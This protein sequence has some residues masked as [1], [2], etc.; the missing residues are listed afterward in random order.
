MIRL[1][2]GEPVLWD[3]RGRAK[4]GEID[5]DT[6]NDRSFLRGGVSTTYYNQKQINNSTP[7]GSAD[8]PVFIT[9]DRAEFD[10]TAETAVY[11]GNARAWQ[12]NN[13][14]R[15]DRLSIDQAGGKFL[16]DGNVQTLI[17]NA[18]LKQNSRETALPASASAGSM[19][20]DRGQRVI[21]YRT[22]VEIRQG[23]D[24]I[25]AGSAD[26]Y[27]DEN[28]E[29]TRTV[30]ESNVTISQPSRKASGDWVEYTAETETAVLRGNPATVT[31][32]ENG[33]SQSG[34]L[35]FSMREKRVT[36]EGRTKQNP[37]GRI[38]SVYKI[39]EL[40]P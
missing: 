13:Y 34:Q 6:R 37:S 17:Y 1:R 10:H 14:I 21:K 16:A 5:F 25:T 39:K 2:G 32:P 3:G 8:K 7:F 40:K 29:V 35:S 22:S 28:N 15:G 30:A 19:T 12:E 33:S 36:T 11:D 9:A 23:T 31:D 26:V 18:K 27:L 20:F 38:R 4:A 24:R